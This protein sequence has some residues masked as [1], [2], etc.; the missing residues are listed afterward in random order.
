MDYTLEI[1]KLIGVPINPSLS[2]P[3]EISAIADVSVVEP[4]EKVFRFDNYDTDVAQILD[5]DTTNANITAV[6]RSPVD[7]TELTFKGLNSQME[8]VHIDDVIDSPDLDVLGRKKLRIAS[9]MD[10]LEL[11][12]ILNAI[13]DGKTPGMVGGTHALEDAIPE[14]SLESGDDLYDVILKMKH[15][16]EDY[17]D[18]YV[19]LAG[20]TVKE[21]ID[22]FDKEKASTFNYSVTLSTKLKELGI[23][24]LKIFGKVKWTGGLHN[25]GAGG[26]ADDAVATRLLSATKAILVCKNS[27][28]ASGKPIIF[29]RRKI[30]EK[31]AK[32]MG[33]EVDNAQ[34]ASI[35]VPTPVPVTNTQKLAYAVYGYEKIIWAI[36]NP[37]AITKTPDL[38]DYL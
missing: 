20:V 19:L 28:I 18:N 26:Y 25:I 11:R 35:V 31:I 14:V 12:C 8:Y 16:V 1:S 21:K 24:V 27:R 37:Y 15:Q 36:V 33:A 9:A 2:V 29:V 3:V 22:V 32:L 17:G 5:V 6:K 10:K 4:G 34:R 7:D 13:I 23:D 38:T 30:S